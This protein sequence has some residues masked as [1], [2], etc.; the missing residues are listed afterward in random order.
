MW[1]LTCDMWHVTCDMWHVTCDM[2]HVTH[3]MW[4]MVG[5][6]ILSKFQLPRF[7]SLGLTVSLRF[8]TKGWANQWIKG[9][10][11][12]SSVGP[13]KLIHVQWLRS[14]SKM[15]HI[16]V[17]YTFEGIFGFVWAGFSK[18]Y[19]LVLFSIL[20]LFSPKH[21]LLQVFLLIKAPKTCKNWFWPEK[22]KT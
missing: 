17:Q 1:H 7:Y 8:W 13:L 2:W 11:L 21:P 5:V 3:D 19:L 16:L 6:N 15:H 14:S 20:V 4:H 18:K 10:L 12:F 9:E 22:R